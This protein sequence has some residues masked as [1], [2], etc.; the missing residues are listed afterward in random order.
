[1][2]YFRPIPMTDPA[3][4]SGALMLAGGW[5]W[6]DRVEVLQ[7]GMPARLIGAGDLPG[8]VLQCLTVPAAQFAGLSLDRPRLM[9]ILN[10]TPDSFSDGGRFVTNEAA[11]AQVQAMA[12][13]DVLDI[14]G[15]STRPGAAEVDLATEVART[16]PIIAAIRAAGEMRAISIDTRK[17]AVA[18]AALAAGAGI[19]NDVSALGFDTG[20]GP[21][22]ARVQVPVILMHAQ[23][24]P[25]VMQADPRY[26]DVLLDVYDALAARI[27]HAV[28]AGIA[29]DKIMIDPGIGFGKT[30][31]HNLALLQRLSLFHSLG[32]P[33]LLGASRKRFV[34]TIGQADDPAQRM[35]GSVAVALAGIAQGVQ[36]LRVHDVGETRQ[37]MRLWSAVT[38]GDQP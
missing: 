24:T 38:V 14:G 10:V 26:D 32:C 23:G 35:P 17:A 2:E 4:P 20:M 6:F 22:A 33:I 28:S 12:G 37:A 29:R 18:E 21:L 5:C 34:G 25:Q 27:D 7:R 30:Q 8:D 13:A 16:A 1:M 9:G 19:I 11:I 3:R 15:E 36:M 31:A